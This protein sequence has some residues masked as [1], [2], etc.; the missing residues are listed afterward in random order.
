MANSIKRAIEQPHQ[1]RHHPH[2]MMAG[3]QPDTPC[4]LMM[5]YMIVMMKLVLVLILILL[6][7]ILKQV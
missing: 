5:K 6:S 2:A 7:I 3:L 1:I 4:S